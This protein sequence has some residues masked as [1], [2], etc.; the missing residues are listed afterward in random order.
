MQLN[1]SVDPQ[2]LQEAFSKVVAC[3]ARD[4]LGAP[5]V[6][7][8]ALPHLVRA[9]AVLLKRYGRQ[10]KAKL[11]KKKAIQV[12]SDGITWNIPFDW[13]VAH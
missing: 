12:V 9:L 11:G 10:N 8:G 4:C 2:R 6:L 1:S 5:N 3:I 13:S 7:S